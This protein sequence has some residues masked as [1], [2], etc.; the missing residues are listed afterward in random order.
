ME[1][2]YQPGCLPSNRIKAI[3]ELTEGQQLANKLREM[4]GQPEKVECDCKSVDSIAVQILGMFDNT[5][6]I[7]NSYSFNEY[8]DILTEA[9][10]YNTSSLDYQKSQNCGE[11]AKFVRSEKNKRG[12]YKRRGN[13]STFMKI[14]SSLIDDGYV[15]RK[16][17]Q[18]AIL[19][20]KNQRNYFRC[21]HKDEKGCRATKQVQKT[22]DEIPKYKTTYN[23]YHTCK[24]SHE[25]VYGISDSLDCSDNS[26]ILDFKTNTL[27]EKK[28]VGSF[29][30]SSKQISKENFS[31]LGLSQEQ[32]SSSDNYTASDPFTQLPDVPLEPMSTIS[33]YEDMIFSGVFSSSSGTQGYEI[34]NMFES[35]DTGDFL[36]QL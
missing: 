9:T 3:Q 17:G 16:Y 6:S 29:F 15:W 5:L 12:C 19:N 11:N 26:L 8:P 20:A 21:T 22:N 1:S 18:K 25:V 35:Y 27:I 10:R 13:S 24:K 30:H 4:L 14:T 28:Q 36:L 2:Y 32:C 31:S 7:L 33:D 23:G 34:D